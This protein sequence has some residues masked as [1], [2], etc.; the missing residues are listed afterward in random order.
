MKTGVLGLGAMG[1][2]MARN[3]HRA[4]HL[5]AVYNRSPDKAQLLAT[6][7]GAQVANSPAELAGLCELIVTS[8]SKDEDLREIIETMAP[9][10]KPGTVVADTSTVNADTARAMAAYLKERGCE[11]LDCPVSGGVEGAKHGT[12]AMMAGGDAATLERVRPT[13][14]CLAKNIVH[15]G[16][17]G[18]GQATKAVNQVMAAGINQ[19]VTEAL[20][21]AQ[22]LGLDM[23]KVIDVVGSGAAGNWFLSHRGK[24]MVA[25]EYPPGFK[26]ALHLKD[27]SICQ[28]MARSLANA[29]LPLV[30]MTSEQYRQLVQS[31]FGDEDISALY[32]LKIASNS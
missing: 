17:S 12:L 18:S 26:L 16:A 9:D 7:T 14:A 3:L 6:E 22:H 8:V 31:G 5:A 15:M 19:A 32:R 10:L 28:Q 2:P 23:D 25:G 27:L 1:A 20:A 29:E 21:F 4:G 30:D 24:S 11:F 13:L